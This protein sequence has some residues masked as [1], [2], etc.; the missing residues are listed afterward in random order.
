[1][2][3]AR[4][5]ID[6]DALRR[7]Y[8]AG[9]TGYDMSVK[10]YCGTQ[11]IKRVLKEMGLSLTKRRNERRDKVV[12]MYNAGATFAEIN[13]TLGYGDTSINAI[14]RARGIERRADAR[15]REYEPRIIA[16]YTGGA[17]VHTAAK[18]AGVAPDTAKR[19]LDRHGIEWRWVGTTN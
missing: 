17:G 3:R 1:M 8:D 2:G 4:I 18:R 11:T 19:V 9:L 13:E 10:H 12:E 14:V 5:E 15:R 6:R 16:E 7:D